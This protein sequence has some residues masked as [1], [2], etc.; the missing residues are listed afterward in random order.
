M[1]SRTTVVT[2]QT[3]KLGTAEW[4]RGEAS[5]VGGNPSVVEELGEGYAGNYAFRATFDT[6]DDA[7]R[8]EAAMREHGCH[9]WRRLKPA[10]VLSWIGERA[11][12]NVAA[13]YSGGMLSKGRVERMDD[14]RI[15]VVPD[16]VEPMNGDVFLIRDIVAIEELALSETPVQGGAESVT[17]DKAS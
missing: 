3:A 10:A 2:V 11:T 6:P 17:R 12:V 1:G 14:E 13:M 8:F 5:Y 7:I 9:V 15:R 16:G 4:A